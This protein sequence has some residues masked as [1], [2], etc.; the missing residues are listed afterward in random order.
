M[1]WQRPAQA[2]QVEA[3]VVAPVSQ[4]LAPE[5]Q[6]ALLRVLEGGEIQPVGSA[7][8]KKVDVRVVAA[9]NKDLETAVKEGKFR[10]DLF[11]RWN[12]FPIFV[13]P[14]RDR[15]EDVPELVR[16]VMARFAAEEGKRVSA[17]SD[18]AMRMLQ[19]YTW[20]GNV[21][22]LENAVFRAVV[23]SDGGTLKP[24]DFP[25]ISGLV[26]TAPSAVSHAALTPAN[27]A[28]DQPVVPDHCSPVLDLLQ[29]LLHLGL[30]FVRDNAGATGDVAVLGIV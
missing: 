25:Q 30:G 20:P 9:T 29:D 1:V 26:G 3:T 17:I 4:H 24:E 16:H 23:L 28:A 5:V 19:A 15:I 7:E 6:Q 22:Q 14:M 2:S 8:R 18:S 12:L 13:P 10:E 27:D 11:Y 21:R